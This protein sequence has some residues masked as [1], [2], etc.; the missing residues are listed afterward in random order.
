MAHGHG[1]GQGA[2]QVLVLHGEV[3]EGF[4]ASVYTSVRDS[5]VSATPQLAKPAATLSC[6]WPG[7]SSSWYMA[8][9]SSHLF[10]AT[11][12]ST[13][14]ALW[15]VSRAASFIAAS[16]MAVAASVPGSAA[17][18]MSLAAAGV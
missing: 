12:A 4:P 5:E 13:V 2:Q 9:R 16:L 11:L 10:S 8:A 17:A 15:S 14:A 3:G 7:L 18:A 6:A 1:R